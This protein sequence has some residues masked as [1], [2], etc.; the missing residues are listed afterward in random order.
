MNIKDLR[1]GDEFMFYCS[2]SKTS[3]CCTNCSRIV[4]EKIVSF[5]GVIVFTD[6]VYFPKSCMRWGYTKF[7]RRW[8]MGFLEKTI[9]KKSLF[10]L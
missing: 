2:A 6:H 9:E 10:F 1:V 4:V 5:R 8:T 7:P 3:G